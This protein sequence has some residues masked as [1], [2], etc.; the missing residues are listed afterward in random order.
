MV[1]KVTNGYKSDGT[2]NIPLYKKKK[3][4]SNVIRPTTKALS[5]FAVIM[6]NTPGFGND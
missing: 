2:V 6:V 4:N 5:F 1:F 3:S